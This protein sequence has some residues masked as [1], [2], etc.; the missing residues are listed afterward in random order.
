M[1]LGFSSGWLSHIISDMMTG[2][3]VRLVCWSKFKVSFVP[4]KFLWLRFNTGNEWEE[5][6]FFIIKLSLI[7]I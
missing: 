6:N 2:A 5:F 4:R 3:G 1:L 7:H